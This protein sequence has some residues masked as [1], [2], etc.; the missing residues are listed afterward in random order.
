MD[1]HKKV[2]AALS[3]WIGSVFDLATEGLVAAK[4]SDFS[5]S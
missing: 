3:A 1:D 4:T 5:G 2:N